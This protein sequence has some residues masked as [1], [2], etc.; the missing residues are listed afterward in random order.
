MMANSRLSSDSLP[1]HQHPI[2]PSV[3]HLDVISCLICPPHCYRKV[4]AS[5]PC[6]AVMGTAVVVMKPNMTADAGPTQISEL[7]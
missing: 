5:A 6:Y 3:I 1:Q 7:N 2:F 4:F